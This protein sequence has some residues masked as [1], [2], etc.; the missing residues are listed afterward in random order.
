MAGKCN[1]TKSKYKP[2]PERQRL[3]K[4]L[5]IVKHVN[6]TGDVNALKALTALGPMVNSKVRPL[7]LPGST[8]FPSRKTLKSQTH[9]LA[10]Q[11]GTVA[12][13]ET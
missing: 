5:G 11:F 2:D 7:I 6:K 9:R 13:D 10:Q 8:R 4:A 1:K 12:A 3:R